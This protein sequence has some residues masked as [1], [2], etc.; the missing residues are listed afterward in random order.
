MVEISNTDIIV[1]LHTIRQFFL[2][3]E[4]LATRRGASHEDR[5]LSQ[6]WFFL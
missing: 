5:L 4:D 6:M 3:D 1:H 2:I